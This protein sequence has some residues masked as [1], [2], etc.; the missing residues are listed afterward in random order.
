MVNNDRR[1]AARAARA[2]ASGGAGGAAAAAVVVPHGATVLEAAA[3]LPAYSVSEQRTTVEQ[4]LAAHTTRAAIA[5][6]GT[7][8]TTGTFAYNS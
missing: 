3:D 6:T 1:A 5:S 7:A 2:A 4:L 8:G